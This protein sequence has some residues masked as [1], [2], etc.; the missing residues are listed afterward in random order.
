MIMDNDKTYYRRHLPHYQPENATFHV[1]FR[2][3]GSLPVSVIETLQLEH[4]QAEREIEKTKDNNERKCLLREYSWSYFQRFDELL[5]GNSTGPLWLR[6]PAVASIVKEALHY[7]D[8]KEYNLLAYCIMPN[9]VHLVV[10]RLAEPTGRVSRADCPT[11][12]LTDILRKLKWNTALRANRILKRS[13]AFW[14]D[15]SYD[16]VVRTDKELEQTIWYV[17]NNSVKARLRRV[18]SWDQWKWTYVKP[19]IL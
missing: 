15:E 3:A 5:D 7:R 16:H 6:E 14:Q 8:E 2:L 1:V 9:H 18:K 11:Y 10:S 12:T 13:G 17:L 19:G 4:E